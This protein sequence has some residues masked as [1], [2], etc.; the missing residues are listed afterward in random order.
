MAET[1]IRQINIL[2]NKIRFLEETDRFEGT[3]IYEMELRLA[4]LQREL[5]SLK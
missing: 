4:E 1:I 2:K 3:G 5:E